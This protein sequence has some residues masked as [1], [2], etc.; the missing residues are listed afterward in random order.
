MSTAN[1]PDLAKARLLALKK[2]GVLKDTPARGKLT[3]SQKR[4]IKKNWDK[5]HDIITAP[6]NTYSV[7]DVSHYEAKDKKALEKSG[8]RIINNKVYIDNQGYGKSTISRKSNLATGGQGKYVV[9]ERMS[10]DGRKKETEFIGTAIEKEGWRNSFLKQYQAG[11]FAKGDFIGIKIGDNGQ[12]RRVMM[13]SL[14]DIFKYVEDDFTPHDPGEDKEALQ[15]KMFLIKM[16]VKDYRDLAANEKTKKEK[17]QEKYQR[18]K[19]AKKLGVTKSKNKL[20]GKVK[21]KK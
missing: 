3:D 21:H 9:V 2:F 16:S 8:Y 7:K 13:Q 11:G 15:E 5:Y 17:N 1:K 6:K 19:K 10:A 18:Q 12:F 20:V 4:T 14:D